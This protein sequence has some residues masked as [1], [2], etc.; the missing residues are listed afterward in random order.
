M[1]R[2]ADALPL[3]AEA[4]RPGENPRPAGDLLASVIATAPPVTHADAAAGN[5]A[6]NYGLRLIDEG[7]Y[8]EAHEVLEA[9]WARAAPN[10]RERHLTQAVIHLANGALK[11]TMRQPNAAHRLAALAAEC[12]ARAFAGHDGCLMGLSAADLAAAGAALPAGAAV[13]LSPKYAL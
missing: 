2:A 5:L 10:G 4:H 7:F 13:K 8:W 3:P 12:A 6:W 9:V 1:T 11:A